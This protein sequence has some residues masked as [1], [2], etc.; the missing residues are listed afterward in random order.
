MTE[1]LK[2]VRGGANVFL[3]LGLSPDEA[4]NLQLR[5]ELMSKIERYVRTSGRTQKACAT[6]LGVTQPRLLVKNAA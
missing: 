3:D 5:S 4:Q 2:T 1:K 6:N